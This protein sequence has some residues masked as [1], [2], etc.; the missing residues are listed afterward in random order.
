MKSGAPFLIDFVTLSSDALHGGGL[1]IQA[2]YRS[3]EYLVVGIKPA[4][5]AVANKRK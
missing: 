4:K 2:G 3:S 1:I 5:L